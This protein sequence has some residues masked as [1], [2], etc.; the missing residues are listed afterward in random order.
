MDI[1][2]INSYFWPISILLVLLAIYNLY[3]TRLKGFIGEQTTASKLSQLNRSRYKVLNNVVLSANGWTSQIDHLVI[4]DFGVFVIE[5][6]NY[7][8]WIMGG[9]HSEYWTQVIYKRKE[10]FYNPIRQNRGHIVALKNCLRRFP[11]INYIPVVVF[12]N[13]ATIKVETDLLVIYS[14]ELTKVI[15][16]YSEAK[17]TTEDKEAIFER[18]NSLNVSRTY[19]RSAHIKSINQRIDERDK[20]I[21][22]NK[23]PRCGGELV[24]RNGKFGRF[25]G[26]GNFPKCKFTVGY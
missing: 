11:N 16:E 7:K 26:C 19:K 24:T 9:E 17:L 14:S 15:K 2:V 8:G 13:S 12:S 22:Q 5:T 1:S 10:Q 3:R 6:K 23:C 4:S 25:I 21:E 20:S 18:I